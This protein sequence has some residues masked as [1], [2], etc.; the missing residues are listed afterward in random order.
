MN[1]MKTAI[2]PILLLACTGGT[3]QATDS[4]P[5]GVQLHGFASQSII[6]TDHNNFFG[7]TQNSASLGFTEL[8]ANISWRVNP[9]LQISAQAIS[10]HA[11]E[12]DN[13]KLRLDYAML[14][15]TAYA[16]ENSRYGIYLGKIKN[17]YGLYNETR[18][19]AFARPSILL[20]QSI[21]FDRL[22]NFAL[23]SPGVG[24]YAQHS[25]ALGDLSV[26]VS[27]VKPNAR[28]DETESAFL[29]QPR[30][31]KIDS[32][33]SYIGRV[34]LERD[35]GRLKLAVTG[36][37]INARYQ[38]GAADRC[39]PVKSVLSPGYSRRNTTPKTGY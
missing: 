27:A 1:T 4:L 24:L 5:D 21:Y 39:R 28:N 9:N 15:L 29:G 7:N 6:S 32:K 31:G 19:V 30:A 23:S 33:T 11:G 16:D 36:V 38:P 17:P 25:S 35:N 22:R 20:P 8:G 18:D 14:N 3:A 34:L 37:H 26:Q 13:G 2:F 12:A 10:R